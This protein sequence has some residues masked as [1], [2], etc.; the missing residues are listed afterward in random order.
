M[1]GDAGYWLGSQRTAE[2]SVIDADSVPALD[3]LIGPESFSKIRNTRN[4]LEGLCAR[5]LL[6]V[7]TRQFLAGHLI[8]ARRPAGWQTSGPPLEEAIRDLERGM[9]EFE[10][11]QQESELAERLFVE[12]KRAGRFDRCVELYLKALYEHPTHRFVLRFAKDAI[13]VGRS[14]GRE[15]EVFAALRHLSAIPLDF[16]G[17]G[18]VAAILAE[19]ERGP[20]PTN[21]Y[22]RPLAASR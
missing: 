6:Q 8:A 14:A 7:E 22:G 20:E 1:A 5:L 15:E 12:L 11:T 9:Q 19:A 10:G 16:E 3:H 13:A 18:A 21:L 4:C 2:V 17:K